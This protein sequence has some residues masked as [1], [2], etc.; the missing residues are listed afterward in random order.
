MAVEQKVN[1][2]ERQNYPN[3]IGQG[4][5]PVEVFHNKKQINAGHVAKAG[6]KH[7]NSGWSGRYSHSSDGQDPFRRIVKENGME[8]SHADP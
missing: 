2:F 3:L 8:T 1:R 4:Q 7:P 5:K 6:D